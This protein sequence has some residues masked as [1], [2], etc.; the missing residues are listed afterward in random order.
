M[1]LKGLAALCL[2][3]LA[4]TANATQITITN[5]TTS[6]ASV[7]INGTCSKEYGVLKVLSSG[8]VDTT[9]LAQLCGI[10]A[11]HCLA[12]V[13]A[14]TTCQDRLMA[15]FF[16]NTAKGNTGEGAAVSP[17]RLAI[18]PYAVTVSQV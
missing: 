18:K 13:F 15:Y 6:L 7:R 12:E 4:T 11:G 17:Y 14:S 1:K 2:T 5:S 9:I 10:N 3:L 8:T 16:F